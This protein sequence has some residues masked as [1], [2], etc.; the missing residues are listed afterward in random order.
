MDQSD[1]TNYMHYWQ[2]CTLLSV[3]WDEV[4]NLIV[5]ELIDVGR[6]CSLSERVVLSVQAVM[7]AITTVRL[8]SKGWE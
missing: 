7:K 3:R 1:C 5:D 2:C 6:H 8:V 4:I